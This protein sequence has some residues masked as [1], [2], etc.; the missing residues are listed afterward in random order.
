MAI[1]IA[2]VYSLITDFFFLIVSTGVSSIKNTRNWYTRDALFNPG[3][4]YFKSSF[5]TRRFEQLLD[6]LFFFLD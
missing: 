4:S 6:N 2:S 1:T 3:K 5:I